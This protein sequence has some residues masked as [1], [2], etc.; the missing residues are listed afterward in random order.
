MDFSHTQQDREKVEF[1]VSCRSLKNMDALSKSDPQV[2]LLYKN[3]QNNKWFE[4]SRTEI[5][6]DNL[7]PNFFKTF[8]V[9]FIFEVQQHIRFDVIDVD[10]PTSFDFIG[11]A[12]T[13]VG[14]IVGSRNQVCI[15]DLVDKS[16]QKT[17]KLIV[18]AEKVGD[19]RELFSCRLAGKKIANDHFFSKTNPFLRVSKGLEDKT[20]LKVYESEFYN[21]NL[22]PIFK[23]FQIKV[24][25]LCN[26]DHL[27]P[28]LVECY[29]HHDGGDHKFVGAC[30]F[31]LQQLFKDNV[32]TVTL[33]DKKGKAAGE[34]QFNEKSLTTKAEFI[35][36]LRGGVQLSLITAIDF[37]G[38]NGNPHQSSSLHYIGDPSQL[39]QYQQ[40]ILA[41]GEILLNYDYD[42]MVPVFGFGGKP[43]LPHFTFHEVLHCF[44]VT[45]YPQNPEVFGL[46]G[47]MGSYINIVNNVDLSGPTLF[48][49][50]I[51][52][53]MKVA[54]MNRD[55]G[56]MVYSIL[57]I[58]TDGAINDMDATVTSVVKAALLP[59]SIIIIGVGNGEFGAMETLDGDEGLVDSSGQKCKR[60]LV[61]FVPFN[62]FKGNTA[63]LAREVLAELPDQFVEYMRLIGKNPN[64]PNIVDIGKMTLQTTVV[65]PGQPGPMNMGGPG[66]MNMGGP[67][68]MNMGGPG[69]SA[70][71]PH[72]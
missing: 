64:P 36:Y 21:G 49:P 24:E 22:N 60:D 13:N 50:L 65:N 25:K 58:L 72:P 59:M 16:K 27:R 53:A 45:G 70:Y 54:T 15:L 10:G 48:N 2:I 35:D 14:K 32:N 71:M 5:I 67:G 28:L 4:H 40:A 39:N 57:L 56:S 23:P 11:E 47:I 17:G 63:A 7:N 62:K 44:P 42:K 61:Q 19:N 20:W 12:E 3:E 26:G 46:E 68:P 43:R 31:T 55:A 29:D 52:E 9:D 51:Q 1:F 18:R 34:I 38:S 66:P 8:T 69:G 6:K 33:H 30:N 41:V 37:T